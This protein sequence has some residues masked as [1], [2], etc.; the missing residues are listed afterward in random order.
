MNHGVH[1]NECFLCL[2]V[3][4]QIRIARSCG[5]SELTENLL[6]CFSQELDQTTFPPVVEKSF[7]FTTCPPTQ[8]VP[9]F[10]DMCH[11]NWC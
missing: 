5:S 2:G 11:S 9:S 8:V 7:F 6:H 1:L 10:S 4:P 3:I